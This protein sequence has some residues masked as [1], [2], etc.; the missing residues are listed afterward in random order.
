MPTELAP[1]PLFPRLF[2]QAE[3]ARWKLEDLPW[4]SLDRTTVTPELIQLVREI[5]AAEATT[6]SATQRFLQEF[7]DDLDF[8]NWI[9]VWFYEETK[10]PQVLVRWLA[11]LGEHCD[12]AF[13]RRARVTVPFMKSR[14]ATLV[15]NI[16]S[17]MV[18]SARY[19][20]LRARSPEPV[21]G[22]I[23]ARLA[24]DEARHAASFF[25]FAQRR[26]AMPA[27]ADADRRDA[28]K[29]L[30]L[31]SKENAHVHHPVNLFKT[32]ASPQVLAA[33]QGRIFRMVGHLIGYPLRTLDDVV[34]HLRDVD[35]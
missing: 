32:A 30:Y 2:G 5:I 34:S 26:L 9:S 4:S 28:L 22:Q 8:T 31:W 1:E 35:R 11:E 25:L 14:M 7:P 12:D 19:M 24:G 27:T 33:M 20:S 18:A 16:V 17:E 6:F 21:L 29:V 3:R 15:T 23:A 13:L 10:H